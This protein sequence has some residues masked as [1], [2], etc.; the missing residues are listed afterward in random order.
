MT[1]LFGLMNGAATLPI[2]GIIPSGH[3]Q[4]HVRYGRQTQIDSLLYS[5]LSEQSWT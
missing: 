2:Y 4:W 3:L 1:S 5:W